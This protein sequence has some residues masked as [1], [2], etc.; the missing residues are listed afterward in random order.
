M[1]FLGGFEQTHFPKQ[2]PPLPVLVDS[3]VTIVV[4]TKC[5]TQVLI[6]TFSRTLRY[7][8]PLNVYHIVLF[9]W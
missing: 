6:T 5:N 9:F 1:I 3:Q 7:L 8:I 2:L 4:P